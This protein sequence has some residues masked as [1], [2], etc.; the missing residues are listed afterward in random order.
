M[1]LPGR[2]GLRVLGLASPLL[3]ATTLIAAGCYDAGTGTLP[4]AD[5]IYFPVGLGVSAGG[6]VLYVANSDFDLQWSGGTI[7]S[8][9]LHQIRE[10]AAREVV[11]PNDPFLV[12][13]YTR[14]VSSPGSCP[15]N[16]PLLK[17]DGSGERQALGETCAPPV[18]NTFLV[19]DSV[20][21]GAFATDIQL[22]CSAAMLTPS[23]WPNGPPCPPT[24]LF[25][26]VRGDATL[27]WLDVGADDGTPPL[28]TDTAATYGAFS[29]GCGRD[30]EGRC[31]ATHHAGDNP[32]AAGDSRNLTMPGEPFGMAQTEDGSAIVITH[33]STTQTSLF[34]SG[35]IPN[36]SSQPVVP[37]LQYILGNVTSG[38]IGIDVIPHDPQAFGPTD[39]I[40]NPAF[41]ETNI[42]TPVI[43]LLRYY[44]DQGDYAASTLY[45][46]FLEKEETI[47]LTSNAGGTDSRGLAIDSTPRIRCKQ[48]LG[49]GATAAQLQACARLPARVFISARTPT[50]LIVGEVGEPS[51]SG[52]GTYDPDAVVLFQNVPLGVGPSRVYLAPIVDSN[53]NYALR[54]FIVCFDSASIYVYDPEAQ[55]VENIIRVGDGP[56][57]MAF[58]PFTFDDVAAGNPVPPDPAPFSSDPALLNKK[59]RYAYVA[60]FTNSFIQA[61]DLD[62]SRADK[63]TFE[64]VALT[65]GD[66][67][68]PKGT[69]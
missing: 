49:P 1:K 31:D 8:Y 20:V 66:P 11:D 43:D 61:I 40:P 52:D 67:T 34:T 9:D 58:D 54:V 5:A 68:A 35:F 60:S 56:Y 28:S 29:L 32:N 21:V 39:T 30:G 41:L 23:A 37:A 19:R 18:D 45:R 47:S 7:Q 24:R 46:P 57:A 62:N 6:N 13:H 3:G 14:P 50:S 38:G 51:P 22:S 26:P 53:G 65:F 10:L 59:Y 48:T 12:P 69:N 64:S 4:P 17:S 33:Q 36:V 27:T 42:T 55:M 15:Y 25:V 16:P 2:S 44:P 63:S